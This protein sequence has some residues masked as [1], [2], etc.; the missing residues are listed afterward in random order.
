[1]G[2]LYIIALYEIFLRNLMGQNADFIEIF[3]QPFRIG[4]TDKTESEERDAFEQL[5]AEMGSSGY[6]LMDSEGD[7]IEFL[8]SNLGDSGYKGYSDLEGRIERKLS[9]FI[10]GHSD[11]MDSIPGQLGHTQGQDTPI[12]LAMLDKRSQDSN[13][14]TNVVN[15]EL[16]PKMR[17]LGFNIPF[18]CYFAF[19]NDTEESKTMKFLSD[20]SAKMLLGG[21]QMDP[22]YFEEQTGIRVVPIADTTQKLT[23]NITKDKTPI[24]V[25]TPIPKT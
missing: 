19:K 14:V 23:D 13:F 22:T 17:N 24:V 25:T 3:S 12:Y 9:K 2:L 16:L 10:L 18:D 15:E 20:I 6:A 8:E 7:S 4:K 5:L 21:L 11:A 1:M